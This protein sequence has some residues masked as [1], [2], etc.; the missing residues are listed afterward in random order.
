MDSIEG[1]ET[2]SSNNWKSVTDLFEQF[3]GP[4]SDLSKNGNILEKN[5]SSSTINHNASTSYI[6]LNTPEHGQ[7]IKTRPQATHLNHEN[8]VDEVQQHASDQHEAPTSISPQDNGNAELILDHTQS[9]QPAEMYQAVSQPFHIP[10]TELLR[11][12]ENTY[13]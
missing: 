7:Y 5:S 13:Q 11:A 3:F 4:D 1:L 10:H 2:N 9:S 6:T 8:T 12:G